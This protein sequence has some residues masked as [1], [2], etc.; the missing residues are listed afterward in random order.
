MRSHAV[1]TVLLCAL[2]A[3]CGGSDDPDQAADA[4]VQ[5]DAAPIADAARPDAPTDEPDAAPPPNAVIHQSG[6][7]RLR[8]AV[9]EKFQLEN[10][11]YPEPDV[12]A[13]IVLLPVAEAS[14]GQTVSISPGGSAHVCP[15]EDSGED[16]ANLDSGSV[17]FERFDL[18]EG[19]G[20]SYDIEAG[21]YTGDF[22][23]VWCE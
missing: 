19:A 17:T 7:D 22:D 2:A 8:I 12:D 5:I 9:A 20:G 14:A 13:V 4:A 3:G 16:C 23:A 21:T 11:C 15:P 18:E 6:D 10:P 1:S